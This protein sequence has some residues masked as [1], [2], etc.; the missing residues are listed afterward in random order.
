MR[1]YRSETSAISLGFTLVEMLVVVSIMAAA[2]A[3]FTN[4]FI[5]R[6]T[7]E[8]V[9][10]IANEMVTLN[11]ALTSYYS[12]Y[13][14]WP[15]Q[16]PDGDIDAPCTDENV[17]EGHDD[18][19]GLEPDYIAGHDRADYAFDC[20]NPVKILVKRYVDTEDMA[21][22]LVAYLPLALSGSEAGADGPVYFVEYHV[23][24]PRLPI[25]VRFF[26]EPAGDDGVLSVDKPDNC[27]SQGG[28]PA[29]SVMPLT[30]CSPQNNR[31]L[32]GYRVDIGGDREEWR[33]SLSARNDTGGF[34]RLE[35]CTFSSTERIRFQ[36]MVFCS[37]E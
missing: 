4:F 30:V 20:T 13:Y 6:L 35:S 12:D 32:G 19:P 7:L 27:E 11:R 29:I 26:N 23:L 16:D 5:N 18:A 10:S 14:R 22:I 3:Y 34:Q 8:E 28:E 1:T 17:F 9:R 24:R 21:D 36:G 15:G 2:A 33:I 25:N 37:R 31:E